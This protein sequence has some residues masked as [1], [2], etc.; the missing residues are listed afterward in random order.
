[1]AG[2]KNLHSISHDHFTGMMLTQIIRKGNSV[3]DDFLKNI[4][5]KVNYTIHFYDQELANHFYLEEQILFPLVR[6]LSEEI[7]GII[8]RIVDEHQFVTE[9]VKEL[10]FKTD[11]ENKL[12]RISRV[13]EEHIKLE[14]RVLFPKIHE[15]LS[16]NELTALARKLFENGYENIYK[17]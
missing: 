12:D 9:L 1:M 4:D 15:A 5:E 7:D 11:L 6:G 3:N 2:Q 10:N 14:E 8:N 16:D 13:L 17:Y